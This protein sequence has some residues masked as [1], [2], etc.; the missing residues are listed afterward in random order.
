M[1]TVP[2]LGED[3]E[4]R[5]KVHNHKPN[6]N[7]L[8]LNQ[9]LKFSEQLKRITNRAVKHLGGVHDVVPE[10]FPFPNIAN[11]DLIPG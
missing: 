1:T 5:Y 6:F 2:T 11:I 10:V 7:C 4:R 3:G 9:F 8:T